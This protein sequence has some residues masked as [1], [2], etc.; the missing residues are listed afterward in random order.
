MTSR[1]PFL[2]LLAGIFPVMGASYRTTNFIVSAPTAQIA[3]QIGQAAEYYRKEKALQWLGHEMPAWGQ[4]CP[5][6]VK[7]TM[8][9]P[10]G[11]TS[12]VFDRGQILKQEM[13]I[14]GPLDRLLASVLPHEV[15]HTVFAYKFRQP[16]PRWADE[17]GSVLS[18]DDEERLRHD[19]LV[20]RHLNEGRAFPL[21]RL[22]T[23]QNYPA[24]M[25]EVGCM[26]A[27][28]FSM[29]NYLVNTS[30][31]QTFLNFVGHGMTR[32]W[33]SAVQTYYRYKSVEELEQAWLAELRRT[34]GRPDA[35]LAKNKAPVDATPTGR[36]VVRLTAPP[37]QPLDES[38]R[39]PV[40]RGRAADQGNGRFG[41][42]A[43][44]PD[45][46]P[47]YIPTSNRRPASPPPVCPTGWQPAGQ[48]APPV[49]VQLGPPQFGPP[50]SPSGIPAPASGSPVGFPR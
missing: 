40:Y 33:D 48:E 32:G 22:F 11:F 8:N 43:R 39:Q 5:L 10:G 28:G 45:Y 37:A 2:V 46:L 31:R 50:P 20:R 19:R 42:T 21:R 29:A 41:D 38:P 7:V 18:E 49:E 15:T 13:N 26:Y 9:G 14:E 17:G 47:E 34:K 25:D 23:L 44:R 27:E 3:Q 6:N 35:V 16:V 30:D 1:R 4:P 12:F 36:V 24:R